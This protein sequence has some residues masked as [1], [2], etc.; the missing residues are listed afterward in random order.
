MWRDIRFF[1]KNQLLL[2]PILFAGMLT[3][4][5][6][7]VLFIG[8]PRADEPIFLHYTAYLGV[9]FIGAWYLVYLIPLGRICAV[10]LN[11]AVAYFLGRQDIFWGYLLVIAAA[12]TAALLLLYSVLLVRLNG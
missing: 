10:A 5:Q 7:I 4:A 1:F 8:I 6:V 2:Y 11:G 9:D 3:L 12:L